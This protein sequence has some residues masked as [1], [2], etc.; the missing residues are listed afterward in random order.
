MAAAF[1]L[2]LMP[3]AQPA[4]SSI[5][6]SVRNVLIAAHDAGGAEI[7]SA[8]VKQHPAL[9]Y[10][11]ILGGPARAIFLRKLGDGIDWR[12]Q[13]QDGWISETDL[14]LTATSYASDLEWQVRRQ[15]RSAG[16]PVVSWLDHWTNYRIRFERGGEAIWPDEFWLADETAWLIAR[17]A[18]SPHSRLVL[19]GNPYVEEL[20][21]LALQLP[22]ETT[23]TD[24]VLY[25]AEPLSRANG[26]IHGDARFG[27][28]DEFDALRLFLNWCQ[29]ELGRGRS[30]KVRLRPH[31][32]EAEHK[33]EAL[34]ANYPDVR[35]L[36]SCG[37]SL[38]EDCTW[39]GLVCGC[40]SMALFVAQTVFQRPIV[41]AI[42]PPGVACLLPL[43]SI[44]YLRDH[45]SVVADLTGI[46]PVL[47]CYE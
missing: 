38:L 14:V 24:H 47:S 32:S 19:A 46:A 17:E 39:A 45:V 11:F 4:M 43:P 7:V 18:F 31:P 22:A 44:T 29:Q 6:E 25:V 33:Y 41:C 3:L 13:I 12:E 34:L 23:R 9:R 27:G 10:R 30:V 36:S 35:V 37:S 15:A 42:P 26:L 8:W 20:R 21:G 16:K 28:Y 5:L 1:Q 40:S 2:S